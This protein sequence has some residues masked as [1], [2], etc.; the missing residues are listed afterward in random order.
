MILNG[1]AKSETLIGSAGIDSMQGGLGNDRIEGRQA[2]DLLIGNEGNDTLLGGI[3]DDSGF[4]QLYAELGLYGGKG[5]DSL[6]G[7]AGADYLAGEEGND[8]LDGGEGN[9]TLNVDAG[10]DSLTGGNGFDELAGDLSKLP[11]NININYTDINNGTVSTG[12][13]FRQIETANII[14]GS[15][16]DRLNFTATIR[17]LNIESGSGNDTLIGGAADDAWWIGGLKA[18]YGNDSV[19]G[20]GGSDYLVGNEG[21][22]TLIGGISND[23]L[24]PGVGSDNL[25]GGSGFDQLDWDLSKQLGNLT[26]VYTNIYSGIASSGTRFRDIEFVSIKSGS[27]ND[28]LNVTATISGNRLNSGSGNDSLVGSF[29][30]DQLDGGNGNDTLLGGAGNDSWSVGGLKGGSGND[31]INGGS[32]NDYLQ[33]SLGNDTLDGG[34]GKDYLEGGSGN[35]LY[36]ID[37]TSDTV[38][39]TSGSDIDTL[40]S[41][42][43]LKLINYSNIDNVTLVGVNPLNVIGSTGRNYLRGNNGNNLLDGGMGLDTL[44]GAAGSDTYVINNVGDKIIENL[45]QGVD[46]VVSSVSYNLMAAA[47]VENLTLTGTS[48]LNGTGNASN[49]NITGNG[50]DNRLDGGMGFDTL[51]GGAG[52]DTYVVNHPIERVVEGYNQG[53][54]QVEASATFNIASLPNI[55]NI[56]LTGSNHINATGNLAN[57]LLIGNAGN[58]QLDGGRGN[59]TLMAGPG[60]DTLIGGLD[61]DLYVLRFGQ[62]SVTNPDRLQDFA[63]GTDKIDLLTNT[64]SS[65]PIPTSLTRAPDS[66]ATNLNILGTQVFIDSNKTIPGNQALGANRAALAVVTTGNI[67]GTYLIIN[68]NVPGFQSNTDIIVNITGYTGP[69]PAFTTPV[70]TFFA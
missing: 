33:G 10:F 50:G 12:T 58:N 8:T 1:T 65:V 48:N 16:N 5:N 46:Q 2:S 38:S 3:G 59:D 47:N 53:V 52:N 25:D 14:T 24:D 51:I 67:T 49:N 22:D 70:S 23:T 7:E 13:R 19:I 9:D 64:G 44:A 21:N 35:D 41:S 31:S 55:E 66:K 28:T 30:E 45:N 43:S 57:N 56:S 34:T 39:E 69:L 27:G 36:I 15:G 4:F 6:T 29:G 54:D 11:G 26:V 63:I 32:G 40:Q 62:S 42:V 61:K 17:G 18:G 68:N 60:L 20:N 37:S